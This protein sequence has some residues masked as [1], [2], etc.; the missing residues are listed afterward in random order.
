MRITSDQ[1][2]GFYV[3]LLNLLRFIAGAGPGGT[4]A[5]ALTSG[6]GGRGERL[7]QFQKERMKLLTTAAFDRGKEEDTFGM[8]DEDWQLYKR[9]SKDTDD[10]DE[11]D[12]QDAELAFLTNRLKVLCLTCDQNYCCMN[13]RRI[14]HSRTA[15][16]YFFAYV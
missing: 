3:Y 16:V 1:I 5:P 11:D 14:T 6:T 12:E 13:S 4:N 8:N 10:L 7:N 2:F 15:F 9:M